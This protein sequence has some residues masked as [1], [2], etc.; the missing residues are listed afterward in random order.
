MRI[1]GY[2][3]EIVPTGG[4][5]RTVRDATQVEDAIGG[6]LRTVAQISGQAVEKQRKTKQVADLTKAQTEILGAIT[7]K[8]VETRKNVD[9]HPN[10]STDFGKS[11][12]ESIDT[13]LANYDDADVKRAAQEH[14]MTLIGRTQ[15]QLVEAGVSVGRDRAR[16]TAFTSMENLKNLAIQSPDKFSEFERNVDS[17]LAGLE[18]DG[19]ISAE[20]RAKTKSLWKSNAWEAIAERDILNNPWNALKK[21]KGNV[22]QVGEES[23]TTLLKAAMNRAETLQNKNKKENAIQAGL[24]FVDAA[25]ATG[26][27]LD[28]A[29]ADH[30][31]AVDEYYKRVLAPKLSEADD[32]AATL[33]SFIGNVGM[34]PKTLQSTIRSQLMAGDTDSVIAVADL[35]DRIDDTNPAILENT[36][37]RK[38]IAFAKMVNQRI[39]AGVDPAMAVEDA[40]KLRDMPGDLEKS[41]RSQ[42]KKEKYVAKNDSFLENADFVDKGWFSSAAS[43]PRAMQTEFDRLVEDNFVLTGGDIDTARTMAA[44]S[45]KR[46]WAIT[47]I[48]GEKRMMRFAPEAVY[49]P[50]DKDTDWIK[51][52]FESATKEL[53]EASIEADFKTDREDAPSY[54]VTISGVPYF[55]EKDVQP[56]LYKD[57]L[58]VRYRPSYE[59]TTRFAERKQAIEQYQKE[60]KRKFTQVKTMRDLLDMPHDLSGAIAEYNEQ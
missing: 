36:V 17:V 42:Y 44:N 28:Y 59:M 34:V 16:A 22:Y 14:A 51:E 35:I 9:N 55:T 24:D 27:P 57:G 21:L 20:S 23:K 6:V 15:A 47:T 32:R 56:P 41:L 50:L 26:I 46:K 11:A 31:N 3:N 2:Q 4:D 54:L 37:K 30:R 38:D 13:I 7:E 58:A 43:V 39:N 40:K 33:A 53:P 12:Q 60:V 49:K 52:Q 18:A 5:L 45:M 8:E 29:N 1:P 48:G 19:T 25:V 10:W